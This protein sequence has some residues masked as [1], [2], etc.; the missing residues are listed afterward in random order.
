MDKIDCFEYCNFK[1]HI[2]KKFNYSYYCH[3][4]KLRLC[5]QCVELHNKDSNLSNH[6]LEKIITDLQKAKLLIKEV[7]RDK[8]I[9]T[10]YEKDKNVQ[11]NFANS[12]LNNFTNLMLKTNNKFSNMFLDY[13]EKYKEKENIK[14]NIEKR[15]DDELFD[16]ETEVEKFEEKMDEAYIRMKSIDEIYNF[17]MNYIIEREN[18]NNNNNILKIEVCNNINSSII[19]KKEIINNNSINELGLNRDIN[20]NNQDNQK[21]L[22][23][24]SDNLKLREPK[25]ITKN[26]FTNESTKKE[27]GFQYQN[28]NISKLR[29]YL[30]KEKVINNSSPYINRKKER[31]YNLNNE[32]NNL[33]EPKFTFGDNE[34][35]KRKLEDLNI[36][37]NIDNSK[38]LINLGKDK[39]NLQQINNYETN[40][41]NICLLSNNVSSNKTEIQDQSN[42]IVTLFNFTLNREG[43]VSIYLNVNIGNVFMIKSVVSN[44]IIYENPY[45]SNKFPYFG[46]RL[47]NIRNKAFVIGGKNIIEEK[48]L[49]NKLIFKLE[50]FN[51]KKKEDSIEIKCSCL[52]DMIFEHVFHHLIY[53]E[54]YNIIFV[55]SGRNQR[56]CEYGIL[57]KNKETIIKWNEMDS[58]RNPREND[59]CFLLNEQ[60]I[61]LLGEKIGLYYNYEVFDIF[62]ISK[63][64][65]W[66]TYNFIPEKSNI[67]IFGLKIPGVIE[68]K[69]CVYVLGGYQHG[70]GNNLNWKINFTSD[71]R[72]KEDNEFKR[73]ESIINLKGDKI[74]N[75]GGILSFY[76]QQK[77]IKLQDSFA[78]L[79]ILGN[80]VKF[81]KSQLDEKL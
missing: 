28:D 59:L 81:T 51:V 29:I 17:T 7:G 1:I 60:Y 64:G 79:N 9:K 38:S 16:F 80:H 3:N 76:G 63:E 24:K 75:Y 46:S 61:F 72:D 47:I 73:I 33:K 56:K 39:I 40:A 4:C 69:D 27:E 13:I 67:G 34:N 53:S 54:I 70:I 58:V 8:I 26:Y 42:N 12:L 2:N 21:I 6:S 65:K 45:Y 41:N 11:V 5:S 71:E 37:P 74:K 50:Y 19:H 66:K 20:I 10:F 22:E 18:K 31:D 15:L 35:K 52:K 23:G 30:N 57:D 44:D 48:A 49:G 77:F 43:E 36:N 25:I 55:I 78:N 62:N 14:K 68:T 32:D